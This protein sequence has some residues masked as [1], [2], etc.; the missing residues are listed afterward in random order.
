MA[1]KLAIFIALA[2]T[3]VA[4]IAAPAASAGLLVTTAESCDTQHFSQPFSR[5]GDYSNYTPVPGGSFE[6]GAKPWTLTGGAKVVSGNESYHVNSPTDSRALSLPAGSTATSPSMCVGLGEPTIRW[7]AKNSSLLGL[8]GSMAVTVLTETS[9][10]VVTETPVGAGLLSSSWNPSLPGVVVTNLLPLLPGDKTA[11][12]FRFRPITGNW[13][14]DD[15]YVDP[16]M[17]R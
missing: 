14:V 2:T 6:S 5:W 12:A 7:F 10:G 13:T 1:R 9:L 3:A 16:Y 4:A 15:V 11:V 8:T 17:K